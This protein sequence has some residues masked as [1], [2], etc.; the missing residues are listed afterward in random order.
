MQAMSAYYSF[1]R[2]PPIVMAHMCSFSGDLPF[3][4]VFSGASWTPGRP[5]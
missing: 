1:R 2:I 4:P 5:F 3:V